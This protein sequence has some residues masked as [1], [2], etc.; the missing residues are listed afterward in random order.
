MM[1]NSTL[2]YFLLSTYI[3]VG[4]LRYLYFMITTIVYIVIVVANTSLIVV[5]CV[6]RSLHEPMYIFLCSLFVNELY[7]STGLFPFLLVQ[8]LSDIHTVSAPLCFL[9]I[10][11]LF[12]YV[13]IQFCNL[14]VMSYD[15]YL[16]ICYPL[17]Y[18]IRM[19]SNK[20]VIFIILIWLYSFVKFLITL[21][22]N[23]RLT[24]CGNI[25]NS[26]YCHNYLVVKL[27]CSD[28]QILRVCF[29]GSKQTRQKAVSTCTPHLVSL[30]NFSFGCSFEM[31]QSRFDMSGVPSVLRIILSLYFLIIQP[32]M[33]PVMN[34]L[35]MSKLRNIC[36][37]V[38]CYKLLAGGR[39]NKS[40]LSDIHTVSAPLCF[41]QIFCLFTYVNN[42]YGY[43]GT[44]LTIFVPLFPIL[45]SYIKILR[46]C[47][48][49]SKQTRQ[50]A[51][52]T[53]TPHLVSLLNFSFGCSFEMFQSRFDMSGVPSVLR[54]IL[55]LYFLIIQPLMNP[56][57]YG[58]QMS[59]LRNIC[60]HVLCYKLLAGGRNNKSFLT[61]SGGI[62]RLRMGSSNVLRYTNV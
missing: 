43:F 44:V 45:F 9:Q 54:I 22:L 49:G 47:F 8:I 53:C 51:V 59:K 34:G 40:I 41:L 30:L 3:H 21:S 31:F 12:T 25:I 15:R 28:T 5:I 37:H 1:V 14:A 19:T 38:L 42:I 50:K 48:S 13:H 4:N 32:L 52:S 33:N 46:V 56:V 7:G 55:S 18:N 61:H 39:N 17:Q 2:S 36:K 60:K 24:L 29:S 10:F 16:A 35:Q 58:L 20:A 26:L 23:I 57:M 62:G 6:N 27:A 11:C